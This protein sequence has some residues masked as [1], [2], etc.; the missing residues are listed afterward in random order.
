M[1]KCR[2]FLIKVQQTKRVEKKNLFESMLASKRG[3]NLFDYGFFGM[4]RLK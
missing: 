4:I 3:K 2:I 1:S